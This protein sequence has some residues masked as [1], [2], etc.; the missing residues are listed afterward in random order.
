MPKN[1]NPKFK[2]GDVVYKKLRTHD[3][4]MVMNVS[5]GC[6]SA[7]HYLLK[8]KA[9]CTGDFAEYELRLVE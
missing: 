8:D 3:T 9:G 1:I 7:Y 5:C 6:D 2:K 4:L